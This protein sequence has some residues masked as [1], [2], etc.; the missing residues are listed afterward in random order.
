[1][2]LRKHLLL[3]STVEAEP[4]KSGTKQ[5]EPPPLTAAGMVDTVL[6][7]RGEEVPPYFRPS[8]I[9]GCPRMNVFWYRRVPRGSVGRVDPRFERIL[10][11]GTALHSLVQG[12]LGHHPLVYF[13][14][15]VPVV[16]L[17]HH[18][19]GSCDGL[20][21]HR[22]S[23]VRWGLE[24]KTMGSEFDKL[25]KPKPAHVI[26]ATIYGV[27][28]G[29]S[30]MNI[31]YLGKEKSAFKEFLVPVSQAAW[32][33]AVER[34]RTYKEFADANELPPFEEEVCAD[35]VSLCAYVEHCEKARGVKPNRLV[36]LRRG[37][38]V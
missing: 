14:P 19:R 23:G 7:Q 30:W 33:F 16:S 32:S 37:K 35:H 5:A 18:I 12:Y 9:A 15:E 29:V 36:A 6:R 20:F 22:E 8:M 34:V 2:S 38:A 28:A 11:T 4:P 17:R 24:L 25:T 3:K 21:I 26:Q 10:D 1:M 27:L 31:L 13:V